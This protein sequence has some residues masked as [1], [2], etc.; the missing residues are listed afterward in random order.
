MLYRLW[1]FIKLLLP[2]F[3]VIN[4]YKRNRAIPANIK[5]A[6]GKIL[7][8]VMVTDKYGIL[9]FSD[10]YY[11]NRIK[12]LQRKRDFI[13]EQTNDLTSELNELSFEARELF[14]NQGETK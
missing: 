3:I 12:Y 9:F 10:A 6:S 13:Q 7:K 5:T 8:A 2:Y 4:M 1:N 11:K 14:L